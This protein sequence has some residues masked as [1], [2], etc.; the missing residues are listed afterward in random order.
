MKYEVRATNDELKCEVGAIKGE[1]N[2]EV[3][4]TK[5]NYEI[6]APS[7]ELKFEVRAMNDQIWKY[8]S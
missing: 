3:Q 2:G 4:T 5:L 8:L 7:A 6:R 1:I